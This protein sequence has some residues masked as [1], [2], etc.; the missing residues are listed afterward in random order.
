MHRA[1]YI[2]AKTWNRVQGGIL[3]KEGVLEDA[4]A[5]ALEAPGVWEKLHLH[6]K[7]PSE[8]PSDLP[9]VSTQEIVEEG[10]TDI[11]LRWSTGHALNLELK[12]GDSPGKDQIE[13]YLRSGVDVLAIAR[14]PGHIEAHRINGR[15]YWG[16]VTW[17][18]LRNLEW[19]DAP[20]EWRQ[21]VHLLDAMGVV[22]KKVE[23]IELEGLVRSWNTRDKLEDWSRKGAAVVEELFQKSDLPWASRSKKGERMNVDASHER[24]VWWISHQPWQDDALAIYAGFFVGRIREGKPDPVLECSLPDLMLSFHVNPEAP[25]GKRIRTDPQLQNALAK[26]TSRAATGSIE[27]EPRLDGSTWEIIRCRESSRILVEAPDPGTKVVEWMRQRAQEWIDDGIVQ[28]ITEL[29]KLG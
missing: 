7:L 20:L 15:I 16:L 21:F 1:E 4:L 6:L 27:R 8:I 14:L 22:V 23:Y 25:R 17:S 9:R 10:R 26:W 11:T 3:Q 2:L 19:N 29:A 18:H 5:A 24:L 12:I 13:R 28:R